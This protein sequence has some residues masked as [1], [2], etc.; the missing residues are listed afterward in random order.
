MEATRGPSRVMPTHLLLPQEIKPPAGDEDS[1]SPLSA[2]AVSFPSPKKFGEKVLGGVLRITRLNV[3]H[4]VTKSFRNWH[5]SQHI[6]QH[7][8][9]EI[10]IP[11]CY[12]NVANRGI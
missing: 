12:R 2:P 8:H 10:S 9:M 11:P 3:P 4:R 1:G 7:R 5:S 6:P